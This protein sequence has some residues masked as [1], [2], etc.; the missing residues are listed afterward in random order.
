[1]GRRP[2]SDEHRDRI[3]A[4]QIKAW[5]DPAI[6]IK[7]T[8]ALNRPDVRDR[9]SVSQSKAWADP[10]IRRKR[11]AAL[12]QAWADPTGRRAALS[13]ETVPA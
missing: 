13:S 11:C 9:Q 1:M 10:E 7:R 4:A 2:F 12:T 8:A 3:R 6:R 5:A